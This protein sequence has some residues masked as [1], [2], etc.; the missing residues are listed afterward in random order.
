MEGGG[1]REQNF[2]TRSMHQYH[3][4]KLNKMQ[5]LE[6]YHKH[7]E[8]KTIWLELDKLYQSIQL[9]FLNTPVEHINP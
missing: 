2:S 1:Q 3:I 7:T 9:L 4:L 6:L 5:V 8:L